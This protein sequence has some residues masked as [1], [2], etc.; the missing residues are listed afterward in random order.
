VKLAR[1][2]S[3]APT[4]DWI[5]DL[6][7]PPHVLLS[8]SASS[9]ARQRFTITSAFS[10]VG[11]HLWAIFSAVILAVKG[12]NWRFP[13]PGHLEKCF[14]P[15]YCVPSVSP[16]RGEQPSRTPS[17]RNSRIPGAVWTVWLS[18]QVPVLCK[19]TCIVV[20]S[21]IFPTTSYQ[22]LLHPPRLAL[23]RI[24]QPTDSQNG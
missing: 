4:F 19:R 18:Q 23:Q 20:L 3:F 17:L 21:A 9:P 15:S 13:R 16:S 24:F 12:S 10:S 22:R 8:L 6:P 5:P 1:L 2:L 7:S 14:C 11:A